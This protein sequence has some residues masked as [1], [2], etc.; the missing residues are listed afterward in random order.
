MR[1]RGGVDG[2]T[3]LSFGLNCFSFNSDFNNYR[4]LNYSN[5]KI[6]IFKL[7]TKSSNYNNFL[8]L[9]FHVIFL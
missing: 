2:N 4:S 3:A 8:I 9:V 6:L 7:N 5:P 1:E